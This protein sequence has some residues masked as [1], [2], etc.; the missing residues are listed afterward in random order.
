MILGNFIV[1]GTLLISEISLNYG[2]S[3]DSTRLE[4]LNYLANSQELG[5]E[6]AQNAEGNEDAITQEGI[7]ETEKTEVTTKDFYRSLTDA[8][9]LITK[10][11]EILYIPAWLYNALIGI[12]IIMLTYTLLVFIGV[13]RGGG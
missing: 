1:G 10:A 13:V 3:G 12:L 9:T 5:V 8:P 7:S 4:E 2:V 6:I 11:A